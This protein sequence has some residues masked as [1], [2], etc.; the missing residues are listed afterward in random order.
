MTILRFFFLYLV[1]GL[2]LSTAHPHSWVGLTS[3]FVIN[4][5]SELIEIRQRWIFDA[6]YSA[7]TLDDLR[8]QFP[9]EV[10]ALKFQSDQIVE[11]LES[12]NYFSNL[13]VNEKSIPIKAPYK[14]H[15]S[16]IKVEDEEL[17]I[18][19]MLFKIIPTSL[20]QGIIDWAVY[21]PTYYVSMQHETVEYVR[22]INNSSSECEP[23]LIQASPTD[24]QAMYAASL[25]KTDK[26]SGGLGN[27][28]AQKARI[29][30]Y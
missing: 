29:T 3:D 28:F 1:T 17:L 13:V 16:S 11:N 10:L 19:E 9:D 27:V 12:K 24:E 22:I 23:A 21:D 20:N 4:E 25:D 26:A 5:N 18:L 8:K 14:W 30:C 15:M 7:L 2:C 6:F